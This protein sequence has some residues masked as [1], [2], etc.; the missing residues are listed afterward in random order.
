MGF[1]GNLLLFA[2]VKKFVNRPRIDKVIA[3]VRV[4]PFFWLTVYIVFIF[5]GGGFGVEAARPEDQRVSWERGSGLLLTSW[6][7]MERCKL[8]VGS[9]AKP[10]PKFI[11]VLYQ[12]CRSHLLI[13]ILSKTTQC[14]FFA[15]NFGVSKHPNDVVVYGSAFRHH[16]F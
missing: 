7:S 2:A 8:L 6:R 12:S 3:M 14:Q 9:G 16:R 5:G 4:A 13:A 15:W 10:R 11:W 1:V